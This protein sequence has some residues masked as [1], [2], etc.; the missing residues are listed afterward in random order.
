MQPARSSRG[1]QLTATDFGAA[2]DTLAPKLTERQRVI[3]LPLD[4]AHGLVG[5]IEV[6]NHV[7]VYA[8]FNVNRIG[9]ER[10]ADR[11][12]PGTAD[13]AQDPLG[14]AGPRDR[15]KGRGAAPTNVSL[16]VDN[17]GA[18]K[19]AFGSEYGAIWLALRPSAGAKEVPLDIVSIE[20]LM[21]G[22]PPVEVLHSLGGRR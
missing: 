21:L 4:S 1:R 18:A 6:G 10:G 3:S 16:R 9:P 17:A 2:G 22:I 11:R 8:G 5:A 12:G 15:R 14:R 13:P 19:A 7:D 20:T